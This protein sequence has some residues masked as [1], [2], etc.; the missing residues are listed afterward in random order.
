MLTFAS[1]NII[2]NKMADYGSLLLVRALESLVGYN[3]RLLVLT[4]LWTLLLAKILRILHHTFHI[5][6]VACVTLTL[7]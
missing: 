3:W 7:H 1:S 2:A 4:A 5:R 6:T